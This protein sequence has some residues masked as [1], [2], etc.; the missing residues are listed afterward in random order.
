MSSKDSSSTEAGGT[1][2]SQDPASGSSPEP[3]LSPE[4]G[5]SPG[6]SDHPGLRPSLLNEEG[7]RRAN[8]GSVPAVAVTLGLLALLVWGLNPRAPKF[9]PAPLEPPRSPCT[10][11]AADFVPSSLTGIPDMALDHLPEAARNRVLLRLNMEPCSCGCKRSLAACRA[12]NPS[13]PVSPQAA[14]ATVKE[15]TAETPSAKPA[16][17]RDSP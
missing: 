11:T 15:E 4:P 9:K 12:V 8:R 3:G 6:R 13:C 5:P 7:S 16:G 14:D 2:P 1:V 10:P 17:H